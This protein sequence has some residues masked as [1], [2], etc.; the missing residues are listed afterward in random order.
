MSDSNVSF[1]AFRFD[2]ER[3]LLFRDGAP[4]AMGQRALALLGALVAAGGKPVSKQA[5][6]DVAWPSQAVEE[7]NLSVQ[8][9]ALRK[10]LGQMPDGGEWIVTVARIGYRFAG[11][12]AAERQMPR[13]EKPSIAVLPFDTAE[14]ADRLFGDGVSEDILNGLSRFASLFV[15]ARHS[16]FRFRGSTDLGDVARQLGVRYLATG[17]LRRSGERLRISAQ[18]IEAATGRQLW[19]NRFD[20]AVT[21]VF[22]VQDEITQLIVS[23]LIGH[24][25]H[26]EIRAV[27]AK[28]TESLEAYDYLLRGIDDLRSY[29]E[30]VNRRAIAMFEKALALDPSYGVAHGY[31]ALALLVEH[32][33]DA[34]PPEIKERALRL[35]TEGV[36]LAPEDSRC[37]VYLSDAYLFTGQYELALDE[38]GKAIALNPNDANALTRL[39]TCLAKAGRAEEGLAAA[40]RAIAANPFHPEYYWS[41]MAIVAYAARQYEEA[42]AASRRLAVHGRYSDHARV[43]AC[44]AQL[45]RM[46]EAREAAAT[47]LRLKPDFNLQTEYFTYMDPADTAHVKDGMRKAGLPG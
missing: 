18:L 22:A 13:G 8:I 39:A 15:I 9:A 47:V 41:D 40:R 1:G 46:E 14:D 38:I 33:F 19:S 2:T 32:R 3:Q 16:S 11:H 29:G 23:S 35:A 6:M 44:L 12:A 20:R 25:E 31:L 27:K 26:L 24:V 37:H 17:S 7:N 10:C 28:P 36:K 5:L 30:D 4:V 42:L 45:G 34:A 43:A 21:D